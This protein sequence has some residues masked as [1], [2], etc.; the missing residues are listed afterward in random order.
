MR[1]FSSN[2]CDRLSWLASFSL[3]SFEFR[4]NERLDQC[5]SR[6]AAGLLKSK[7][8]AVVKAREACFNKC[9]ED[10]GT[11]KDAKVRKLIS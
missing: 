8:P 9:K 3:Q 1:K 4:F 11:E 6:K 5:S 2:F 10:M 7:I